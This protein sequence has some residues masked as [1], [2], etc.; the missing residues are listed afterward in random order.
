M[1]T[2]LTLDP[3]VAAMLRKAVA[4][5]K[6]SFKEVVNAALRSGLPSIV[7]PPTQKKRFVQRVGSP[8]EFLIDVSDNAAIY[9]M[10]DEEDYGD[11]SRRQSPP[12]RD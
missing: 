10:W 4:G 6:S 9:E 7:A 1:R 2:T 12:V 5:G 8:A 11:L 3:D